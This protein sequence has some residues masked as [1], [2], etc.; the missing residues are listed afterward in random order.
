MFSDAVEWILLNKCHISFVCHILDDFLIIEPAS[1][2]P[3]HSQACKVSLSSM[4]LTFR[5]RGIPVT[6]NKTQGPENVLE[7]M[8]IILDSDKMD[9]RLPLDK[10]ER[11]L[12]SLA[13]FESGKS[14][15]LKELQS[16]IG[17]LNF[18][19]KVVPPGRPFLQRM[20]EL[21]CNVSQPHH[22]IKLSSGF[23]KDLHTWK[24]FIS[25]WNGAAFFLSTSWIDSHSL[26][27]YT[28]A[29]GTSGFG[30]IFGPRW[31]Q[32]SW[33]THQQLDQPGIS[34]AWQEL[35]AIVVACNLWGMLLLTNALSFSV[36]TSP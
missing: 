16:L 19:C 30:G 2:S 28:D 31:F 21:T 36:I 8:V 29:S 26:E 6:V 24:T 18:A 22:H 5:N 35:F 4:L 7:F 32:G 17:T 23:F 1:S 25:H 27:L 14:C 33:Q 15:T 11:I 12:A 3:P 20:V 34:I 10:V 13:S 9:A